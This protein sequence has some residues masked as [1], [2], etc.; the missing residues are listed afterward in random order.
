MILL[1]TNV[2]SEL[3]K[4]A[5][6]PRVVA[7]LDRQP[8]TSIWTTS[9]TYLEI[10]YGLQILPEGKRRDLLM[11]AFD[12]VIMNKIERRVA[13]FDISAAQHAADLMTARQ[14]S[15]KPGEL[16]DTMIGGIAMAANAA[17]ATGNIRHFDD[18]HVRVINPWAETI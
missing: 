4:K 16:R 18:L 9:V 10:R 12:I 6:D 5:P 15:G 14:R 1:D 13:V 7:W 8:R 3:M 17:L 2:L 11:E